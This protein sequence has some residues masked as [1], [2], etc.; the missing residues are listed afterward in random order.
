MAAPLIL[1]LDTTN[2]RLIASFLSSINPLAGLT[3]E[4]GDLVPLQLHF[5]Q[6]NNSS[7]TSGQLPYSYIDPA[8]VLPVSL[9][10]GTIGQAPIA[11]TFTVTYGA[12]TTSALAFNISAAALSTALNALASVVSA[13]GVT[14]TGN[15]GGPF[16]IT[17]TTPGTISTGFTV[18][19]GDLSPSSQGIV[20][21]AVTGSSGVN[22][23]QVIT[24]IQNPAALQNTWTATYGAITVTRLQAGGAGLNEIQ[25]ISIP[26][27]TY[28][29]AYSLAFPNSSPKSTGA[30]GYQATAAEVQA[31]LQALT[32]IGCE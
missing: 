4:A 13:G 11:G 32:T 31:A 6:A 7:G 5:L 22:E 26:Q 3:L 19:A 15:A 17:F 27:G 1:Y 23:V 21:V 14:I 12:N 9:A 18:N 25:R 10:L 28:A 20:S 24:L 30:L 2:K 8:S 29:G 16:R